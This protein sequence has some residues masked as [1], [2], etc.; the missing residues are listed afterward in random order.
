MPIAV[1]TSVP[2][3]QSTD[4]TSPDGFIRATVLPASAGVFIRVD[5]SAVRLDPSYHWPTPFYL[6]IWREEADGTQSVVRGAQGIAQ[7]GGIAHAYDDE[8]R[9]GQIVT[10]WAVAEQT[11]GVDVVTGRVQVL[12]WEPDGG[13]TSPGVWIKSLE[14]PDL[15]VPVRCL[16]WSAGSYGSRNAAADVWGAADPAVVTDVRKSYSTTLVA[17]TADEEEYQAFLSAVGGSVVYIVG[18]ERHRRRTGYY[19]VG[20]IAPAR[21]GKAY[22][23]YDAWTVNL[24]GMSRP[25]APTWSLVVPGRSYADRKRNFTTYQAVRDG[26]PNDG[27]NLVNSVM[28]PSL[29]VDLTN[30]QTYVSANV[31]RARITSD[32]KHGTACVQHTQLTASAGGTSWTINPVAVAGQKVQVG[33]WVK[34]PA[35]ATSAALVWRNGTTLLSSQSVTL[36]PAGVWTRLTGSYT[37]AAGEVCDRIGVSIAAPIAALWSADAALSEIGNTLHTYADGSFD[38]GWSWDGAA[39]ASSS[40][41]HRTYGAG[42]EPY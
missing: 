15:S 35:S 36:P 5:F 23:E 20:D 39:N 17:L 27:L 33:I 7:Y 13:F 24:V 34:T 19:L 28:N 11:T 32:F 1:T 2:Q 9:F 25:S 26:N 12:T 22:S 8:V 42:V 30:T 3:A 38:G 31:S 10:Y 37:L 16:D 18:L 6:T 40:R 21:I 14:D 4:S 41:R 29:E